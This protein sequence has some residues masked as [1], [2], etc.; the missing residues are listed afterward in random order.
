[1][2]K[3]NEFRPLEII[4]A[5]KTTELFLFF[6][7]NITKLVFLWPNISQKNFKVLNIYICLV[8]GRMNT[9]HR[10]V[11]GSKAG[12]HEYPWQVYIELKK[13]VN[14]GICGGS[15]IGDLWVLTAAHCCIG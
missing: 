2:K 10:I 13:N 11:G 6:Y 5:K 14:V 15:I 12:I 8:C 1:M 9:G 7:K 4:L 3:E